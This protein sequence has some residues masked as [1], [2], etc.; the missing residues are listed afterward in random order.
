[1]IDLTCTCEHETLTDDDLWLLNQLDHY[2]IE[3]DYSTDC[4]CTSDDD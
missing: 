3:Y 1:M 4:V 2:G